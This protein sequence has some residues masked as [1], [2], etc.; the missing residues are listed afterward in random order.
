MNIGAG[1]KDAKNKDI[2]EE[3]D[4]F[5]KNQTKLHSIKNS[6]EESHTFLYERF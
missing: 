2:E 4:D 6:L 3:I 1:S 5:Y